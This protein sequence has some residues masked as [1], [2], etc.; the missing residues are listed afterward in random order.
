MP[1]AIVHDI[2]YLRTNLSLLLL[3]YMYVID[4]PR[5]LLRRLR[6]IL[7]FNLNFAFIYNLLVRFLHLFIDCS[8]ALL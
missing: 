4:Y 5:N 7:V 2:F 1:N 3:H 8:A 6:T